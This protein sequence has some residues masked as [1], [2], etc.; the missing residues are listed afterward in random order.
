MAKGKHYGPGLWGEPGEPVYIGI[1][2]SYSGFAITIYKSDTEYFTRVDKFEGKGIDRL[3]AIYQH[4]NVMLE[5]INEE[6]HIV[7]VAIEGYAFGSQMANMLG[8]LGGVVK[9]AL[10]GYGVY[11]LII[12]PTTLKKYVTGK[13]TG[14]PKSQ[15]LLHAYKKWGAEFGDDNACDSFALARLAAGVAD[16]AYEKEILEKLTGP[17][18]REN[19]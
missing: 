2:Q 12:P 3:E 9:L 4:I 14:I 5:G 6:N 16:L 11:P 10:K 18:Y 15:M 8:E 17:T 13:G 19:R 7:D 1:D